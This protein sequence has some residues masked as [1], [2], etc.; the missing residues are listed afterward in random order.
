MDRKAVTK[1]ES[2]LNTATQLLAELRQCKN[3]A[4]FCSKWYLFLVSAKN[5]YTSLEKGARE[6]AKTRQW[7]FAEKKSERHDDPLLQYLFQARDDDEHGL[8]PVTAYDPGGLAVGVRKEGFSNAVGL[9]MVDGKMTVTSLDGLPVLVKR[10]P[11]RV[12]LIEVTGRGGIKY[13]PPKFHLGQPIDD[14]AP[15]HVAELAVAYLTG[16]LEDARARATQAMA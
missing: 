15:L 1:A 9:T 12:R 8:E 16:L 5:V 6:N 7:W 11:P 14:P 10:E 4:D 13:T 2:R 3:Y